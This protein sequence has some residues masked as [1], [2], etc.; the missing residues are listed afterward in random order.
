MAS[1]K[2]PC[3]IDHPRTAEE[4]KEKDHDRQKEGRPEIGLLQH[5]G[6]DEARDEEGGQKSE[7]EAPDLLLLLGQKVGKKDDQTELGKFRRLKGERKDL[8]PAHRPA[9]PDPDAR[10]QDGDQAQECSE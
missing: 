1:K 8:Q 4:E 3:D 9:C 5:Q 2:A 6:D 10:D 7:G